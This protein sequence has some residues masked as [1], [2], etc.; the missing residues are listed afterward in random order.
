MLLKMTQGA[1]QIK[2]ILCI[3]RTE[4]SFK[5][6]VFGSIQ[7][8]SPSESFMKC[9]NLCSFCVS[10]TNSTDTTA[11]KLQSQNDQFTGF[12]GCLYVQ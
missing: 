11:N 8:I 6:S 12:G 1:P 7:K 3:I 2:I 4:A 5:Q 9:C 10:L